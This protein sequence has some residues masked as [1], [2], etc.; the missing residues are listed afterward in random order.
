MLLFMCI[1]LKISFYNF[2]NFS[3]FIL[4]ILG[5][6]WYTVQVLNTEHIRRHAIQTRRINY[7]R[8]ITY[9]KENPQKSIT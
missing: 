4:E 5:P 9:T 3:D 7:I 8:I 2:K 6:I 1:I